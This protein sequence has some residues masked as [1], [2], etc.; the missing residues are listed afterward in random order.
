[1]TWLI[2]ILAG[3]ICLRSSPSPLVQVTGVA[4]ALALAAQIL[5][6][7]SLDTFALPQMWMVPGLVTAVVAMSQKE[8]AL[9]AVSVIR[10]LVRAAP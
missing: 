2:A 1:V 9:R 7:F 4:G 5:E 3:S 6:G 10:N 8:S